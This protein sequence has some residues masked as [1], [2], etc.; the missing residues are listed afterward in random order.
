MAL[1]LILGHLTS[2]CFVCPGGNC[3]IDVT[4]DR[5]VIVTGVWDAFKT[6]PLHFTFADEVDSILFNLTKIHSCNMT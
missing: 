5:V 1:F 6:F 2:N 3:S 4:V